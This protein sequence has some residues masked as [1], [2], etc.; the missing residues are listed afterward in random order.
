M[1]AREWA[2]SGLLGAVANLGLDLSRSSLRFSGSLLYSV[3]IM[4]NTSL[5]LLMLRAAWRYNR[6]EEG[7]RSWTIPFVKKPRRTDVRFL[8]GVVVGGLQALALRPR[9]AY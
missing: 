7:C 9:S 2:S 3:K 4:A 6:Q 8:Q 1:F 5:L